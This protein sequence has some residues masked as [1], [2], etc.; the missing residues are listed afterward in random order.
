MPIGRKGLKMRAS[1]QGNQVLS[2]TIILNNKSEKD[3]HYLLKYFAST[4]AGF[5]NNK[6]P[7]FVDPVHYLYV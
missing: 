6:K 1:T 2:K 7:F 5:I 3:E 4:I